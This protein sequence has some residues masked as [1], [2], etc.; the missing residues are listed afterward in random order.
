[1]RFF[2]PKWQHPNPEVRRQAVEA[3]APDNAEVLTQVALQDEIADVRKVALSRI[4]DLKFLRKAV[5]DE[6]DQE[7][8]EFAIKHLS[9]CLAGVNQEPQPM[10]LRLDILTRHPEPEL[11][12][13]VAMNGAEPELRK[14]AQELVKQQ[15]VLGEVAVKDPVFANRLAALERINDS[16]VLEKIFRETRKHDKQIHRLSRAKLDAL[17]EAREKT[18]RNHSECEE[19]CN[20]L[21]QMGQ[22]SNWE[23]E[24]VEFDGLDE[25][26]K[27]L[28]GEAEDSFQARYAAARDAFLKVSASFREARAAKEQEWAAARSAKQLILAEL[29][30]RCAELNDL[31]SL[32]E[33]AESQNTSELESWQTAWN[34]VPGLSDPQVKL[35]DETYAQNLHAMRKQLDLLRH[36]RETE[37]AL[38]IL[39][40]EAQNLL[41]SK[42]PI[43]E[44]QVKSL[45]RRWEAKQGASDTSALASE[46]ERYEGLHKQLRTRLIHQVEKRNKEFEKLPDMLNKLESLVNDKVLKEA[47]PMHDRLQSSLNQLH[48][49]GMPQDKLAPFVKR[50]HRVT[51]Q[52]RELQSWR[53]WGADEARERFCEEMEALISSEDKPAELAARIRHLR[54]EWNNLRSDGGAT[55]KTLRKRFDK[56]ANEAY[57]PCETF[58]KQQSEQRNNN[59]EKKHELLNQLE[60]YL[61]TVEW[62][63]MDWKAA[64]KFHRQLSN[65]WRRAG[66]VDRREAK[67]IDGRYQKAM[68][69]IN[70]HLEQEHKR[71]LLQRWGLIDQVRALMN[72]EDINKAIDEC[73][74]L[75]TQWQTTVA[76]KRKLENEIWQEFREACDAVF[77]R[78]K[79][80][81]DE[82]HAEEQQHKAQKQEICTSIEQLSEARHD[83]LDSAERKLHKLLDAWKEGG[84]VAKRDSAALEQRFEKAQIKFRQH[85]DALVAAEENAQLNLLRDKADLCGKLEQLL[86]DPESATELETIEQ[87]WNNLSQLSENSTNAL[88]QKRYAQVIDALKDGAGE[89]RTQLLDELK[90]NLES[91][92]ELCLRM[93]ILSGVQSPPELQQ[94][95]M[96]FQANRLAE[97]MG[98]GEEDPVGKIAELELS[99]CLT[100]SAP[101][102]EEAGLQQRFEKAH[103]AADAKNT[104]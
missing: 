89:K 9:E 78:R 65:D 54:G 81:Q 35:L 7:V 67:E 82:R 46:I 77:A 29:T 62:S 83:E 22:G 48:A 84:V 1:M 66:P 36:C 44:N 63:H 87:S 19:V 73:K 92:K 96:E 97:A 32:N 43:T 68:G 79:Q 27:R 14:S 75:Q 34:L 6:R 76:G 71:N 55:G 10:D 91:R 8:R 11:L 61:D 90:A 101:T 47:V 37:A 103:Q 69:V 40:D 51:P 26:W 25:R 49:M 100:G 80:Q 99:F 20:R 60:S 33:E 70:E 30:K 18:A 17:L 23:N 13:F 16:D 98:Q 38:N 28:S 94:A 4:H 12:A 72:L 57:K 31:Q 15:K 104:E 52:V 39:I 86:D 41:D 88:M 93:E 50:L 74:Q 53:T 59:L 3:L 64:V 85:K 2:K 5:D 24:L 42:K 102:S 21:E 58:F 95:R 56:A 45:D